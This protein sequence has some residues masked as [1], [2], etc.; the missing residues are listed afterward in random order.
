[1]C[2][3]GATK[4]ENT[5]YSTRVVLPRKQKQR[6]PLFIDAGLQWRIR[7]SASGA[8]TLAPISTLGVLPKYIGEYA[9]A[10]GCVRIWSRNGLLDFV[11]D[12]LIP[13]ALFSHFCFELCPL[14]PETLERT[15]QGIVWN[16]KRFKTQ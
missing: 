5:E 12:L 1:M 14:K 2:H 4:F 13:L 16:G 10:L 3:R 15:H 6:L 8:Y 7:T 9:L 11:C